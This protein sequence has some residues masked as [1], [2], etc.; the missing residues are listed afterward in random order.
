M[1]SVLGAVH[2]CECV[3]GVTWVTSHLT[4]VSGE[5]GAGP[6][7][8]H[9]LDRPH[10]FQSPNAGLISAVPK[11]GRGT[12]PTFS[13]TCGSL[14]DMWMRLTLYHRFLFQKSFD[15]FL[16]IYLIGSGS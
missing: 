12:T 16:K 3:S 4:S 6:S 8:C 13:G 11:W 15:K 5:V 9:A 10:S 1:F 7:P 14:T 2:D